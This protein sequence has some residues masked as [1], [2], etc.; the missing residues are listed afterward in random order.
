MHGA[1]NIVPGLERQMTGLK[2]GDKIEAIVP[3]AE[4]YGEYQEPGPQAVPR[5]SFP[6][7]APLELRMTFQVQSDGHQFP[8]WITK[9]E[10]EQVWIDANHPLAGVTL[11]FDVE[12]T[13]IRMAEPAEL[14]NGKPDR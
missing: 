10:D 12:V 13:S 9:I 4:G 6:P 2:V 11:K 1:R 7:E 5:S 8:V 14:A 3:P